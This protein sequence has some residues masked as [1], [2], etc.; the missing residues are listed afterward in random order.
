L[1]NVCIDYSFLFILVFNLSNYPKCCTI[2][3][4]YLIKT[5]NK[6][7]RLVLIYY[8]KEFLSTLL[9]IYR[10]LVG[11]IFNYSFF[12]VNRIA[13]TNIQKLQVIQDRVIRCIFREQWNCSSYS[14]GKLSGVL[15][16]K[17]RLSQLGCKYLTKAIA[18]KNPL[19]SL[20][21]KEYYNS[22]STY[23]K[24]GGISTTLCLFTSLNSILYAL[25]IFIYL[26]VWLLT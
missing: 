24:N 2:S 18:N 5:K 19:T 14:L 17:K 8:I 11:S 16:V 9:N 7:N 20:L 1:L 10:A 4:S 6:N 25:K 26:V 21:V 15:S 22:R 23:R 13:Y 12:G 3:K